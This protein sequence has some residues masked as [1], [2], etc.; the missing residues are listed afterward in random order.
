[1]EQ[2]IETLKDKKSTPFVRLMDAVF[3]D[4][5]NTMNSKIEHTTN[6]FEALMLQNKIVKQIKRYVK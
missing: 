1:M 4:Q 3:D 2:A 5:Q 6:T